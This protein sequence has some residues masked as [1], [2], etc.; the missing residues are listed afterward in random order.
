MTRMSLCSSG[1]RNVGKRPVARPPEWS[2][3]AGDVM[4]AIGAP[5]RTPPVRSPSRNQLVSPAQGQVQPRRV[6]R[7]P[8]AMTCHGQFTTP[9]SL[10]TLPKL[11]AEPCLSA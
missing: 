3:R 2:T 4:D 6:R 8:A 7:D 5:H 10:S 1:T 9:A 11:D